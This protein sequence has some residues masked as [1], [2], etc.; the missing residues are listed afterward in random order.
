MAHAQ[1]LDEYAAWVSNSFQNPV[2]IV[3]GYHEFEL[4]AVA[5]RNS[6]DPRIAKM[7][8]DYSWAGD[9]A[10]KILQYVESPKREVCESQGF[11]A[12]DLALLKGADV[13]DLCGSWLE[14]CIKGSVREFM[15]NKIPVVVNDEL[16][17]PDDKRHLDEGGRYLESDLT[18]FRFDYTALYFPKINA[19]LFIP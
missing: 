4:L 15:R 1:D 9:R 8:R 11:D 3:T 10:R 5:G 14:S 6:K 7:M 17:M 2:T 18:N 13:V 12:V 19:T 16:V